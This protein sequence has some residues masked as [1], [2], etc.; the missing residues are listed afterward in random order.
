M[1]Y[2]EE[3]GFYAISPIKSPALFWNTRY[4]SPVYLSLLIY[5]L[6]TADVLNIERSLPVYEVFKIL[7]SDLQLKV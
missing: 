7:D 4:I 5:N 1:Q 2:R 6:T 3:R